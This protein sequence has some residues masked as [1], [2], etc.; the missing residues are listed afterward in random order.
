MR[1]IGV[2]IEFSNKPAVTAVCNISHYQPKS[3][4]GLQDE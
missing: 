2:Y 4:S 3:S 1:I